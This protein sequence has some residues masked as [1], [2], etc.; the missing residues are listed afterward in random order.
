MTDSA[1]Q[2]EIRRRFIELRGNWGAFWDM[3]LELDPEFV[4][5]YGTFSS[6]PW[7]KGKLSVKVKEF[8][9][10]ALDAST[11]HLY[12]SGTRVHVQ[13]AIRAGA[14]RPEVMEVLEVVSQLGSQ[15]MVVSLPILAEES[16]RL[17]HDGAEANVS[18]ADLKEAYLAL[19][20]F[21]EDELDLLL[22]WDEEFF[23]AFLRFSEVSR[24][25][26]ALMPVEREFV[27][28]AINAAV[29]HLNPTAIRQHIRNALE[30]G[31]SEAEIIEVLELVSA[32]GI[33]TMTE[34]ASIVF[35]EFQRDDVGD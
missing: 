14:T 1:R 33:H 11:T 22:G 7:L 30:A 21:P 31:A 12:S 18:T 27:Q 15:T 26:G 5:A 25:K 13:N 32:V 35:E 10:I 29:T 3:L 16:E 8:V 9:Y 17:G 20:T 19:K 2:E 23:R 4:D 34:S 28:I 24:E 6:V